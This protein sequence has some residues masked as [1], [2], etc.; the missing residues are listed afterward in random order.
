[1]SAACISASPPRNGY[2]GPKG[3]S[4][5]KFSAQCEIA[6]SI[7]SRFNRPNAVKIALARASSS[8]RVSLVIS[9]R[10]F[11]GLSDLSTGSPEV[12]EIETRAHALDRYRRMA[13]PAKSTWL[14]VL[15]TGQG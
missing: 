1:V 4:I 9:A 7:P 12:V 6:S 3:H 15:S 13:E 5:R 8:C 2:P 14:P 10:S 11:P